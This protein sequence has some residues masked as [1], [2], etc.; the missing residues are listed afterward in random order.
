MKKFMLS[1]AVMMAMAISAN[2]QSNVKKDGEKKCE[3][4]E[5]CQRA[6]ECK[7][8]C[9]KKT[10][11]C[12]KACKSKE[13]ACSKKSGEQNSSCCKKASECKKTCDKTNK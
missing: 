9:D 12:K 13:K 3:K 4:K 8:A 5:C 7:K 11:D 10:A 6:A 2:A 1:L